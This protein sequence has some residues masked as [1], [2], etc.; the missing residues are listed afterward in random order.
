MTRKIVYSIDVLLCCIFLMF[1]Y[2]NMQY[3][4]FSLLGVTLPGVLLTVFPAFLHINIDFLLYRK[5]NMAIW[6]IIVYMTI[7]IGYMYYPI[8]NANGLAWRYC[9]NYLQAVNHE[10]FYIP[11]DR[12]VLERAFMAEWK[13]ISVALLDL[14]TV[15]M[16]ICAYAILFFRKRLAKKTTS[17]G[18]LFGA[19]MFYD[20]AGKRFLQFAAIFVCAYLLGRRM[21]AQLSAVGVVVLPTVAYYFLNKY[22]GNAPRKWEYVVLILALSCFANSQHIAGTPKI[23]MMITSAVVIFALCIRMLVTTR[24]WAVSLLTLILTG[25]VIPIFALGYNVLVGTECGRLS[26]YTDQFIHRGVSFVYKE[27][28]GKMRIG[29]RSRYRVVLPAK[30]KNILPIV[31]PEI[32]VEEV[33]EQGD[34]IKRLIHTKRVRSVMAYKADGDSI[35]YCPASDFYMDP[36]TNEWRYPVQ[37]DL[38]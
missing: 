20:N 16:P 10:T 17:F 29:I 7:F 35:I 24:K 23:V 9:L 14:W 26:D 36:I 21:D 30:Y 22:I 5:E 38:K 3:Y 11:A 2:H 6:P 25:F 19:Y 32:Y 37:E 15:F 4:H 1:A 31:S 28:D 12:I 13:N 27:V 18:K 8:N 34:T 33:T